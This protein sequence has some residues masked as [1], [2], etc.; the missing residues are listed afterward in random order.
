MITHPDGV[1]GTL[2]GSVCQAHER[3][4]GINVAQIEQANTELH[5]VS[6]GMV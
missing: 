2:L 4:G 1:E 5:T 3:L 6:S